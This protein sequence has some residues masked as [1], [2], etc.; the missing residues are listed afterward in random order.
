LSRSLMARHSP[1][2]RWRS[3][4]SQPPGPSTAS[5]PAADGGAGTSR[6]PRL[7]SSPSNR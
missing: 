6:K 4:G 5:M 7:P 1:G 3:N 2:P